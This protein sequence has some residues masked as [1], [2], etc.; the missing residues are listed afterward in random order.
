MSST[1]REQTFSGAPT[2]ISD[3][4][5]NAFREMIY[6]VAG[7]SLSPTKR[8]LVCSRLSKRLREL[9]IPTFAEY[10]AYLVSEGTGSDECQAMINCITTNKTSFFRE[11]HHFDFLRDQFLPRLKDRVLAGQ[12]RRLRIWS[13][14]CSTGEEPYTIAMTL[15]QHFGGQAASWDLRILASDIDTEVL[16]RAQHGAYPPALVDEIPSDLRQRYFQKIAADHADLW[17]A[18][19]ELKRLITFRQVNLMDNP[20]PIHTRFDLIFCRNVLIYFDRETQIRIVSRQAE[21]LTDDGVLF[22]GHSENIDWSASLLTSLGHTMFVRKGANNR[23]PSATTVNNAP[24]LTERLRHGQAAPR[25]VTPPAALPVPQSTVPGSAG[26]PA[27]RLIIGEVLAAAEPTELGTLLGSCVAVCL[28]DPERAVGGM[29]HFM[30]P[31]DVGTSNNPSRYGE[32]SMVSLIDKVIQ[33]GGRRERLQAK[34]FGGAHVLPTSPH[35]DIGDQNIRFA[36]QFLAQQNIP[37]VS[38]RVGGDFP[39]DL[40][41]L[42]H[43]GKAFVR[44]LTETPTAGVVEEELKYLQQKLTSPTVR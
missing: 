29:N 41:F 31:R 34:V 7:I 18:R 13:A 4:E 44:V 10:Y 2:Q 21:L 14:G 15:L 26:L 9:N 43:T 3:R 25:R 19:P 8:A 33:V 22:L 11:S 39:V 12:P 36:R 32:A 30:L 35:A 37:I 42:P 6:E 17:Q 16:T 27:K 5:F 23:P 28:Y 40:R 24:S 1:D 20:W 38:E